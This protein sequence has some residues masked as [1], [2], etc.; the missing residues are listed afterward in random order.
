[1]IL[2]HFTTVESVEAIKREGL[3][4]WP[5]KADADYLSY[6]GDGPS[7]FWLCNTLTLEISSAELEELQQRDPDQPFVS[8]R[9]LNIQTAEPIA[10]FT[11][12]LS[13]HAPPRLPD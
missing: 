12:S 11:I 8:K 3:Q 7:I 13:S 1:M 6:V 10:R 4:A 2:Y 5:Q 9:W